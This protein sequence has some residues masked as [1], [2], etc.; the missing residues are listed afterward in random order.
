[1]KRLFL[2]L[3]LCLF[4]Q[5]AWAGW[6]VNYKANYGEEKNQ[7]FYD[8]GKVNI[9]DT[10]IYSG[11][12]VLAVNRDSRAYWKGSSQQFCDAFKAYFQKMQ[13]MIPAQYKPVPISKKKVRRKKIGTKSIAGFSATGYN[14]VVDGV[15]EAKVWVSSDSGLS[16]IIDVER[17]LSKRMK[18]LEGTD[19]S[20]VERSKLY[21]QT[22]EGAFILADSNR[23][24]VSIKR[25]SIPSGRFK[26]PVGY[27]HFSN[28]QKFVD[29][30]NNHS[31]SSSR[32]PS[33]ASS[34][35][36]S[37]DAP[38]EQQSPSAQDDSWASSNEG[39]DQ[40][41][42]TADDDEMPNMDDIK[43]GA[44]EMLKNLGGLFGN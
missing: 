28:Y 38:V 22:V 25:K 9:E 36:R 34:P 10:M 32:A 41:G 24:V 21:K 6:V 29:Y 2:M 42:E 18:C 4:A 30:T 33:R 26:A 15:Q 16:G 13:S 14:F 35:P 7:E 19:S 37:F 1:M 12:N 44:T 3:C 40:S 39:T 31:K 43:E 11:T 20:G 27:K 17:T 5:S 8:D 23:Q